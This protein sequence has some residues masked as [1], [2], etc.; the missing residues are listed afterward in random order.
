[1]AHRAGEQGDSSGPQAPSSLGSGALA[2]GAPLGHRAGEPGDL[3][4]GSRPESMLAAEGM[5][6]RRRH[7]SW[8]PAMGYGDGGIGGG[9]LSSRARLGAAGSAARRDSARGTA[10]LRL[11]TVVTALRWVESS[12]RSSAVGWCGGAQRVVGDFFFFLSCDLVLVSGSQNH[13]GSRRQPFLLGSTF[14]C[15]A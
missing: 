14:S 3:L 7:S 8:C 13:N 12:C 5:G 15:R 6:T 2:C 11:G 4:Q 9:R 1:M 10:E